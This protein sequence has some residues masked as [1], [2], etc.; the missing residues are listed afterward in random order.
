MRSGKTDWYFRFTP[1]S[2]MV[3]VGTT[4][5]PCKMRR[6]PELGLDVGRERTPTNINFTTTIKS[7]LLR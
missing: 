7:P 4:P 5:K 2:K 3:E 6:S 1:A